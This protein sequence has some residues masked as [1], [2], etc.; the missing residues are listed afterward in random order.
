MMRCS[1]YSEKRGR[2]CL[3]MLE[4]AWPMLVSL[5]SVS[6]PLACLCRSRT[7]HG[8]SDISSWQCWCPHCDNQKSL[9]CTVGRSLHCAWSPKGWWMSWLRCSGVRER[10]S[11]RIRLTMLEKM[12]SLGFDSQGPWQ[13][14][15]RPYP[16]HPQKLVRRQRRVV[17]RCLMLLHEPVL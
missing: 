15:D 11:Q 1:L 14:D 7:K 10:L 6:E 2:I 12:I 16:F 17:L 5:H 4:V 9:K 8:M 3:D 13:I